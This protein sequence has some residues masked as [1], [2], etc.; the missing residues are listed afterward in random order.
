[1]VSE[2]ASGK[3]RR[4]LTVAFLTWALGSFALLFA[5]LQSASGWVGVAGLLFLVLAGVGEAMGGLF[6]I[7][8]R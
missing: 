3:H 1:M 8:H 5:L 4:V 6:D 2:Y 7:N